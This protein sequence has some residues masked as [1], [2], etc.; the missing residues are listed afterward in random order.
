MNTKEQ[1]IKLVQ[2]ACDFYGITLK[3]LQSL[4]GRNHFKICK[5]DNGN[6]VRIAE[7]R[8]A[9]S[10]FIYQHCPMKLVEIAPLVGYKDHSTMSTYRMKIEYYIATEDPKFYPYYLKVIDLASDLGISMKLSRVKSH[11]KITFVDYSGK[12]VL[13]D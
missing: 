5:D 12:L 6:T 7:I 1:A 13:V 8:M 4:R 11:Q 3:Q 2:A 10:Y 9:L